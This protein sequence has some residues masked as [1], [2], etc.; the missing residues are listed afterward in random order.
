VRPIEFVLE[1]ATRE[2]SR[3]TAEELI[4]I[5]DEAAKIQREPEKREDVW[6]ESKREGH[7]QWVAEYHADKDVPPGLGE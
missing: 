4:F 6:S 7:R 1:Q 5:L 3:T 2:A